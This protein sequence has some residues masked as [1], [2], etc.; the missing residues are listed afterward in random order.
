MRPIRGAGRSGMVVQVAGKVGKTRNHRENEC[1]K[2][3]TVVPW[4]LI[5][6]TALDSG[7]RADR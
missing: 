2:G 4:N 5:G 6:E 1:G 3:L 7:D